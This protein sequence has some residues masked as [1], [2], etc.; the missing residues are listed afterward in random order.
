[1]SQPIQR[2]DVSARLQD[3]FRLVGRVRPSLE[4]YIIPT[5]QVA[6][7]GM[8]A[9]PPI[10]RTGHWGGLT[11][12]VAAEYTALQIVNPTGSN[13]VISVNSIQVMPA[14]TV[15]L[16]AAFGTFTFGTGPV[17]IATEQYV[18]RR[19]DDPLVQLSTGNVSAAG[20]GGLAAASCARWRLLTSWMPPIPLDGWVLGPGDTLVFCCDAVN[21]SMYW[22]L[23]WET[24]ALL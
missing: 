6:D 9:A 4:E 18:D 16:Y 24:F 3:L 19:S 12:G 20:I 22:N 10:R 8:A 14:N 21:I 5:V 15:S 11:A 13:N 7:L 17:A 1:M 2:P 23:S